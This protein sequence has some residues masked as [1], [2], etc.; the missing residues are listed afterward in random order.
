MDK[1]QELIELRRL[2]FYPSAFDARYWQGGLHSLLDVDTMRATHEEDRGSHFVF[3]F[4]ADGKIQAYARFSLSVSPTTVFGDQLDVENV[5]PIFVHVLVAHP[6]LRGKHIETVWKRVNQKGK[7]GHLLYSLILDFGG[8]SGGNLVSADVCVS[9]IPNIPSL[10]LHAN[11][12]FVPLGGPLGLRTARFDSRN[13][14]EAVQFLRL[15]RSI[16]HRGQ[17]LRSRDGKLQLVTK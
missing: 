8:Q 11:L 9:P 4:D 16:P 17:L 3:C 1:Y 5:A 7:I 12:Q 6:G 15:V 2:Y 10:A 14:E 13:R